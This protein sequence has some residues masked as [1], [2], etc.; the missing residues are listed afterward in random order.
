MNIKK[1][2]ISLLM[3][4]AIV[5]PLFADSDARPKTAAEKSFFQQVIK[6]CDTAVSGIKT[7]WEEDSRSGNEETDY[8]NTDSEKYPL[9]HYY[10]IAWQDSA[11][12]QEARSKLEQEMMLLVPAMKENMNS[13]NTGGIEKL[14]EQLG[15]AAEAGNTVEMQRIQKEIE[16]LTE[17]MKA[18]MAPLDKNMKDLTAKNAP[19]DVEL[20]VRISINNFSESFDTQPQAGKLNS[21]IPFYRVE[22]GRMHNDSWVEG[23][24]WVFLGSDW[25]SR[26]DGE[27]F[28]MEHPEFAE[29]PSKSIRTVVVRVQGDNKRALETLNSMD[30]SVLNGLIK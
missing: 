8:I 30:F 19:R 22:D 6:V 7:A 18:D 20:S 5:S 15:K 17:K 23:A 29:R 10:R 25:K 28:F 26:Q 12:I 9:T 21:G 11:R 3:V 4:M 1:T 24:T 14:A 13:A 16:I 2:I 27:V